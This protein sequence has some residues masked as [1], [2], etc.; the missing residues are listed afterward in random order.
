MSKL[1]VA[2]RN[3]QVELISEMFKCIVHGVCTYLLTCVGNPV[4][5]RSL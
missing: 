4:S 1:I 3:F 2:L 5:A